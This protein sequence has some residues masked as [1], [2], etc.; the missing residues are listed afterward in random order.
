MGRSFVLIFIVFVGCTHEQ[1]SK[2]SPAQTEETAHA[3]IQPRKFSQGEVHYIRNCADC[4][5]WEGRG[6]GPV[7]EFMRVSPP[8]LQRRELLAEKFEKQFVDLVL[9]GRSSK[10][11]LTN[12]AGPQTDAEISELLAHLRKLPT[13]DWN[14]TIAGQEVYDNLCINCHGLYGEGDGVLAS[15][16][17]VTLPDLSASDYQ[18]QHSDN[19]LQQI[20][21]KGKNAMPGTEDI[22]DPKDIDNV[23][24]FVRLLSPGYVKYDRFC[25][26][27]HGPNGSPVDYIILNREEDLAVYDD[28]DIPAL[29]GAYLEAHN[30]QQLRKSIQHMLEANSAT[31]P[32]FS[33]ELKPS[34]VREIFRYLNSLIPG[35]S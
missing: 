23:V 8:V 6:N 29:N 7:A 12:N 34:E 11:S 35:S 13:I 17:P 2:M 15:Q 26:G 1:A 20:I 18:R 19:E 3:A 22:L 25:V 32:H 21:A 31:M 4:H 16:L 30:E 33:E 5:G 24:A 10:L 9:N 14:K 28:I 27:C